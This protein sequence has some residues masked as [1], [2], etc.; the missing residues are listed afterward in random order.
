[1]MVFYDNDGNRVTPADLQQIVYDEDSKERSL[2]SLKLRLLEEE[3]LHANLQQKMHQMTRNDAKRELEREREME[4][5][6]AKIVEESNDMFGFEAKKLA[7]MLSK[8]AK[9]DFRDTIKVYPEDM[10]P[11]A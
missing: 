4:E 5:I 9:A 3:R 11:G 2:K 10:V 8:N 1:M 6:Q 7:Q